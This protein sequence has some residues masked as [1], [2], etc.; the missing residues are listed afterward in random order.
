[1]ANDQRITIVDDHQLLAETVQAALTGRGFAVEIVPPVSMDELAPAVTETAPRLVLLDLEL[2]PFGDTTPVIPSLVESGI[3]VLVLSGLSDR[4]RI[5]AALAAGAVGYQSKS[6]GF[7]ALV[8]TAS[9]TANA[10]HP[11]DPEGRDTLISEYQRSRAARAERF[12]PFVALT[13]RER[14]TLR[15]LAQGLS[16]RQIAESWVVSE[17]TVRS[18]VQ[19]VLIK[20]GAGSQVQAISLALQSGWLVPN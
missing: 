16:V 11:L 10:D 6:A 4:P 18:H 13:D 2:G 8:E 15:A 5:G 19:R 7:L 12:A 14:A 17:A 20:L 1:V 3:K 9:A